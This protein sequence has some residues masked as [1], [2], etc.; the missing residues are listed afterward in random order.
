MKKI[1]FL[2]A[3]FGA[4][5]YAQTF[6]NPY[7]DITDVFL[8]EEITSVS[9]A[10]ASI[11]NNDDETVLLNHISTIANVTPG[12]SYTIQVQ[13]NS[14]GDYDNE[15]IAYIDWNQNGLLT[16]AGEYYYIGKLTDTNGNDGVIASKSILVPTTATTG[17]TR[18]RI[19]KVFTAE[20]EDFV[21]YP[22]PCAIAAEDLEFEEVSDSFGQA[23][24]FTVNVGA[25][26]VNS[27]DLNSLAVYP[28]PAKD[29]LN[30]K[31]K[32]DI[33]D[34]K[35]YNLL[36]QEVLSQKAGQSDF[37][38][39]TSKLSAGTYVVKLSAEGGQHNFKLVKE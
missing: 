23:L 31:Y 35:V 4:G 27:F 21:L 10:G 37:Q 6:P 28:N 29:V 2:L 38:L 15:Y 25:L 33:Q 5:A 39:N 34:V 8:V 26:S 11:T 32:S 18:I 36:G 30:V 7:C 22:T 1:T 20:L 3:L 9:F 12:Q 17:N 24:D 16:D 13:G 19:I 14:H